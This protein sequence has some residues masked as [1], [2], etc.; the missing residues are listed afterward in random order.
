MLKQPG[1][2]LRFFKIDGWSDFIFELSVKWMFV[3]VLAET[4]SQCNK[5]IKLYIEVV[6]RGYLSRF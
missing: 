3:C 5:L 6:D 1:S 4:G 2:F